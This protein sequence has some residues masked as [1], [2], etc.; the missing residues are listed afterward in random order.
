MGSERD[1]HIR[2]YEAVEQP[3]GSWFH[4]VDNE[5]YWYNEE[6]LVHR[7]DGPA[8]LYPDGDISWYLY[9]YKYDF[10]EWLKL[11]PIS[12]EQKMLLRLQ[13]EP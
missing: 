11:T 5:I 3:D 12:D 7:V 9:D 10:D 2:D 8:I 13:Y 4:H 6:G 1:E